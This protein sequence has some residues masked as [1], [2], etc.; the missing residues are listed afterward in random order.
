MSSRNATCSRQAAWVRNAV[1]SSYRSTSR[2][3]T[4]VWSSPRTARSPQWRN[5]AMAV[6]NA[7]LGSFFAAFV[8]PSSRTLA[9]RV[10]GTST[11][12][13]PAPS[14]CCASSLPS[15]PVDSTAHIR[16]A[17]EAP[18]TPTTGPSGPGRRSAATGP[19]PFVAIDRHC[20]VGR[21]VG[22]DP[23]DHCHEVLLV[24]A[25]MRHDGHS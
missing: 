18:P 11:T 1:R 14:S 5:P 12:C 17:P 7:S 4:A 24:N 21:L 23:D 10:G 13:S 6:A 3:I 16:S 9:V 2:R 25:W 8:E 20:G 22:V 15:P 19:R